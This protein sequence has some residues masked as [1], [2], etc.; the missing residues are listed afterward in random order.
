MDNE[1]QIEKVRPIKVEVRRRNPNQRLF[2][3]YASMID[4]TQGVTFTLTYTNHSCND[5][6]SNRP[7]L[8][9]PQKN[10]PKRQP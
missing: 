10:A 1:K 2:E 8:P 7:E 3:F 5:L 4:R 9:Q 6:S